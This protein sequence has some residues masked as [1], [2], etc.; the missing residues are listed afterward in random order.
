MKRALMLF[1]ALFVSACESSRTI[2]T[3][4]HPKGQEIRCVGVN[5]KHKVPGIDYD[6]SGRNV[7]IG[8]LGIEMVAPPVVVLLSELE[9]PIADT[10]KTP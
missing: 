2:P 6:Y 8:I 3:K 10:T 1:A 9:C 5:G 7:V 4:A